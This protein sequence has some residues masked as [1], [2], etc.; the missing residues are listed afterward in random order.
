M[1]LG[2]T[3]ELRI[4]EKRYDSSSFECVIIYGRRRV[5][6][7]ALIREFVKDKP[8][9]FHTAIEFNAQ[10]NLDALSQSIASYAQANAPA[11]DYP[12][13]PNFRAAFETVFRLA[14][15]QR[16]IL[17]IDE[18]PYLAK[19]D[20]SVSSILQSLIDQHKDN[21]KLMLILCGSSMSFMENQVLGYQSPLYGRR[22]AQLKIE[23]FD[24]LQSR[25]W[26][27]NMSAEDAAQV[28]GIT[29]GIPQYLRQ[30]DQSLSLERNIADNILDPGCYMSEETDNLLK[31]ELR[32][33]TEYNSVIQA[34]ANGASRLNEIATAC[35]MES[36]VTANYLRNLMDLRI[37]AKEYP[38]GSPT[39][40]KTIYHLEDTFFQ[41]RY[42]MINP[43]TLLISSGRIEDAARRIMNG[44]PRFMGPVFERMCRQW[45]LAHN[46]VD[47]PFLAVDMGRWWGNNPV[48]KRQE[49]IDI[50]VSDGADQAIY[51]ECKWR[52][53][54][55]G[56][57]EL[58]TLIERSRLLPR[59]HQF[60]YLFSKSGFTEQLRI[61]ASDDARITLI[62]FAHMK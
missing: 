9:I 20:G 39:T 5:G 17:V 30:F 28:Y 62:D 36:G 8:A 53:Q 42:Q 52:N 60:Y 25:A 29:Y 32:N 33:P 26:M 14:H 44:M 55:T 31:Q 2:R 45:F 47:L 3:R 1:F 19:A 35:N 48:L 24:Y 38:F 41:F 43:N 58:D 4:L 22:T 15:S 46:G 27:S 7:T 51:A 56:T 61:R 34:I 50:V 12:V 10:S 21:S 40:K 59:R 23:P 16:T 49:E 37:V 18:Y 6:K 57:H 13:Y 54:L 11:D